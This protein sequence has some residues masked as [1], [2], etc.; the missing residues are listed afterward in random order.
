MKDVGKCLE[1][2][3]LFVL[4]RMIASDKTTSIQYTLLKK[5][6]VVVRFTTSVHCTYVTILSLDKT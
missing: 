4:H 5:K 2:I 3:S 1:T 6:K